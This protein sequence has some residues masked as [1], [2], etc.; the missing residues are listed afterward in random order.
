[1]DQF[2]EMRSMEWIVVDSRG[3]I[4]YKYYGKG[5]NFNLC[6][7]LS[8]LSCDRV[9]LWSVIWVITILAPYFS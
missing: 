5:I 7:F 4:K 8:P 9:P 1:M 3:L 2:G 6:S